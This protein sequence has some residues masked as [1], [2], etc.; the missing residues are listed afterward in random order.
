[1]HICFVQI[2]DSRIEALQLQIRALKDAEKD[3]NQLLSS[4]KSKV[5]SRDR[6]IEKLRQYVTIRPGK[7][8]VANGMSSELLSNN[9]SKDSELRL[10]S[11]QMQLDMLQKRNINLEKKLKSSICKKDL[12]LKKFVKI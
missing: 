1:M 2:T 8:N 11:A 4:M 12:F 6:E 9:E 5:E 7:D 10:K 3:K